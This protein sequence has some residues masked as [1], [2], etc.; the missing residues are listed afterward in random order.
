M[1][2]GQKQPA[3]KKNRGRPSAFKEEYLEQATKLCRLGATD[4]EI[5]DFFG[6]AES[7]LNKWKLEKPGFSE[8][9]KAGK[10][11]ADARVA[12]A[13]FSR[14]TGYSHPDVHISSYMGDVTVT[15]ITKHYPPETL[16]C[17]YWLKNRQPEIWRDKREP[18]DGNDEPPE[19]RSFTYNV[20]DG[21]KA[22]N[23]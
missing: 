15:P 19:S 20:I 8:S 5:A 11:L 10:M 3:Q 6:V 17:I 1:A 18:G 9:L 23:G 12:E 21:R 13:L 14:A 7:T 4:K 2:R 22:A 16:A